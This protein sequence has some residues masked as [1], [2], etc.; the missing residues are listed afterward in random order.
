M[1]TMKQLSIFLAAALFAVAS[2]RADP[3]P[4]PV[5]TTVAYVNGKMNVAVWYK[6]P[7][8]RPRPWSRRSRM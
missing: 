6:A 1:T 4:A 5:V 2:V 7:I 8:R 3:P